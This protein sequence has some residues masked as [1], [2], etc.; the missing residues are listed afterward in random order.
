MGPNAL[1]PTRPKY[2]VGHGSSSRNSSSHS[3]CCRRDKTS[4]A[5]RL[6]TS[7]VSTTARLPS[8]VGLVSCQN[9][10][11]DHEL[12]SV[13]MLPRLAV[14]QTTAAGFSQR[15]KLTTPADQQRNSAKVEMRK[16]SDYIADVI[17]T[18]DVTDTELPTRR[19]TGYA[20]TS[21]TAYSS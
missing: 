21:S 19:W 7:T 1:L 3:C 10:N 14:T 12:L 20:L 11:I 8:R 6:G 16:Q 15:T 18:E 9:D 5:R 17:C 13:D 4:W 2:W